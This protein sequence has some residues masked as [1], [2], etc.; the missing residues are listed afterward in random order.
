MQGSVCLRVLTK[1]DVKAIY[2]LGLQSFR[3]EFWYTRKYL[4]ETLLPPCY[5]CGAFVGENLV[6]AIMVRPLD[7]PKFWIFF[8]AVDKTF[9]RHHIGDMLLRKSESKCTKDFPILFVDVGAEDL[10]AIKFYEKEGFKRLA[11]VKDWFGIGTTGYIYS[12]RVV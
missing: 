6:G 1:K 7:R 11:K 10:A 2:T 3:G 12:K 4:V 9:R 5:A 8:L